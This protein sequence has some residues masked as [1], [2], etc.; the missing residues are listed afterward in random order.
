MKKINRQMMAAESKM[1]QAKREMIEANLRLVIS[2]AKKYV[3]RH[4]FSGSDPGRQ[5]RPDESRRQI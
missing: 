3:N 5:Y 4:A 1:R 2:I